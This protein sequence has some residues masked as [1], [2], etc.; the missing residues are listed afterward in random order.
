M[1]ECVDL[2]LPPNELGQST[3][4]SALQPRAQLP[5][6]SHLIELDLLA[7]PF[8]PGRS[9][10]LELEVS[11]NESA[12]MSA[13]HYRARRGQRLEPCGEAGRMA[14]RRVLGVVDAG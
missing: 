12:G 4:R 11:L 7:D 1:L 2:A 10:A 3:R 8:D 9:Q 14:N 13:D 5:E 6:A